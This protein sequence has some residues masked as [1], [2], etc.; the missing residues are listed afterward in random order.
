MSTMDDTDTAV[1]SV[2][3]AC[4]L[5][6]PFAVLLVALRFYTARSILRTIRWD[7]CKC[8]STPPPTPTCLHRR[9]SLTHNTA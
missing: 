8:P 4:A 5:S 1:T 6:P 3:L 9:W 2:V 7:D